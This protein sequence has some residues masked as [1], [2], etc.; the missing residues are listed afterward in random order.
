MDDKKVYRVHV[1]YTFSGAFDVAADSEADA[2]QKIMEQC[3]LVL[4][5]GIETTLPDEEIDWEFD[6]HSDCDI[7]K[8]TQL[9]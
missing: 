8:M 2:H 9:K 1:N 5:H 4:G 7:I 3:G 6:I